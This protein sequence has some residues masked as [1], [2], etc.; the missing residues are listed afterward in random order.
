[1]TFWMGRTDEAMAAYLQARA[2]QEALVAAPGASG[3]Q[4]H[5]LAATVFGLGKCLHSMGRYSEAEADFRTA[6]TMFRKLVEEYPDAAEYRSSLADNQLQL[7]VVLWKAG[8]PRATEAEVRTALGIYQK[9]A[10]ENPA[11]TRFRYKVANGREWLGG[12]LLCT[13]GRP[14]EA[15][16][17]CRAGL[18]IVRRL[19]DDNPAVT[20]FRELLAIA[21]DNLGRLLLQRGEPVAAEAESRTALAILQRLADEHRADPSYPDRLAFFHY[22]L[23]D[24]LRVLGRLDEA[25]GCYDRAITAVGP[26]APWIR[27]TMTGDG[28]SRTR[29]G[30]AGWPSG[31]AAIRPVRRPIRGRVRLEDGLPPSPWNLF[32]VACCHA[33]LAG[34]AGRAGSGVPAAEGEAEAAKAM[35]WLRKAIAN[36]YRNTNELRIESALDPLRDRPD[37]KKLMGDLEKKSPAEQAKK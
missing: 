36:G 18:A 7:G 27:P 29:C 37:F 19:V 23:G 34:L 2:E 28:C 13:A 32:E 33:A 8:R 21:H 3:E 12:L 4:R 6:L 25:R 9:L 30:D 5:D 1:M 24:A 11:V 31:T 20:D 15:E 10:D 16:A 14:A 22:R 35:E 17:E 26:A